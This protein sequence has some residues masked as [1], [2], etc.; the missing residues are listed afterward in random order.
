MP[1]YACT[2]ASQLKLSIQTCYKCHHHP[3]WSRPCSTAKPLGCTASEA[4]AC[5]IRKYTH[6]SARPLLPIWWIFVTTGG[7]TLNESNSCSINCFDDALIIQ[8]GLYLL[9]GWT[10][11]VAQ[12]QQHQPALSGNTPTGLPSHPCPCGLPSPLVARPLMTALVLNPL[13]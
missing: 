3:D 5:S 13:L 4:W 9:D 1:C 6:R 7:Q 11:K 2:I 10:L 8:P 12:H